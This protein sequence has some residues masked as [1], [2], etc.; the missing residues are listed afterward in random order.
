[1]Q[2]DAAIIAADD[3]DADALREVIDCDLSEFPGDVESRKALLRSWR[4]TA[5]AH[6]ARDLVRAEI[7]HRM[8]TREVKR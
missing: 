6:A 8:L 2:A 4:D 7:L 5:R 1:M 3:I